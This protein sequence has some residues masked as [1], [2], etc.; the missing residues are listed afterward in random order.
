MA[1]V[2]ACQLLFSFAPSHLTQLS[3]DTAKAEVGWV[4]PGPASPHEPVR[5]PV[6][7]FFPDYISGRCI[8]TCWSKSQ[9]LMTGPSLLST[10]V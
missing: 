1:D 7:Q 8:V 10:S 4:S 6:N 3:E 2:K 9:R 5:P